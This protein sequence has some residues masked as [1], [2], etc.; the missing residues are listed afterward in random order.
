MLE[1][2]PVERIQVNP[3]CGLKTR[4]NEE[5]ISALESMFIG[6]KEVRRELLA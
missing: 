5:V 1:K 2:I 6:A 3:D 4:G